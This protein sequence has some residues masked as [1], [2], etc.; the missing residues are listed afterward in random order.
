MTDKGGMI[1]MLKLGFDFDFNPVCFTAFHPLPRTSSYYGQ[2]ELRVRALSVEQKVQYFGL[3]FLTGDG[4]E[5]GCQVISQEENWTVMAFKADRI[6]GLEKRIKGTRTI[7]RI[8][9]EVYDDKLVW[10]VGLFDN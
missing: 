4:I 10:T 2:E 8:L 7:V 6:H 3:K 1:K 9:K 5:S